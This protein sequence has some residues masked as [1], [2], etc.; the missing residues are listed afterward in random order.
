MEQ[1]EFA[2]KRSSW[3]VIKNE[4]SDKISVFIIGESVR[5]DFMEVYNAIE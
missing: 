2:K 4:K 3:K 5:R 1:E